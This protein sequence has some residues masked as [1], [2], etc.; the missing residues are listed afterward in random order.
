MTAQFVIDSSV[1]IAFERNQ[2]RDIYPT[3]WDRVETLLRSGDAV[4]P[5]EALSELERGTDD[6]AGWVRETGAVCDTD[7]AMIAVVAQISTRHP[8]WV[9]ETKNAA[10]PFIIATAKVLGAVI[11]TNEKTRNLVTVDAN[12]K[13]PQ[14]AAEF[15]VK[16]VTTNDLFRQLQWQF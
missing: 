14:V 16:A 15:G 4:I 2:P 8:D 11:V 6:L 13:I 10:D 12:M 3:L 5:R 7:A 1:L 9:R